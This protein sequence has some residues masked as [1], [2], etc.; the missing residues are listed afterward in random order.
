M[1]KESEGEETERRR[2]IQRRGQ[3]GVDGMR[4]DGGFKCTTIIYHIANLLHR[5]LHQLIA[6]VA[7][8]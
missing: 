7:M 2:D 3:Y 5:Y 1:D 8:Y 4:L 6:A